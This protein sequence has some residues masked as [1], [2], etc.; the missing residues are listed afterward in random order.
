[1]K[2]GPRHRHKKRGE[3]RRWMSTNRLKGPENDAKFSRRKSLSFVER[4]SFFRP[5]P[6]GSALADRMNIQPSIRGRLQ[7][8]RLHL[9]KTANGNETEIFKR[10]TLYA[11]DPKK[12]AASPD[13]YRHQMFLILSRNFNT[14]ICINRDLIR[15]LIQLKTQ[16]N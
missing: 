10:S 11:N 9:K 4:K 2:G 1:M 12:F 8:T 5:D 7:M 15:M 3:R 16:F 13:A 6:S 14:K